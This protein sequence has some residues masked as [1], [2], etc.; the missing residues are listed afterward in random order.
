MT[1]ADLGTEDLPAI[2][3]M[4]PHVTETRHA[5]TTGYASRQ[6]SLRG[7][8]YGKTRPGG[9]PLGLERGWEAPF[10]IN[11]GRRKYLVHP[12][13]AVAG[14][15]LCKTCRFIAEP[16][17]TSAADMSEAL[18]INLPSPLPDMALTAVS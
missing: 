15:D 11:I 4:H 7:F 17:D 9:R 8:W 1:P 16:D 13:F 18:L 14:C 5:T 2:R 6:P 10:R 3:E 12:G